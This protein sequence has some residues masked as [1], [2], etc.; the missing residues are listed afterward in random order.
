MEHSLEQELRDAGYTGDFALEPLIEACGGRFKSL[1][2][3]SNGRWTARYGTRR[4]APRKACDGAT[5]TEAVAMLYL[6]LYGKK[7]NNK[8][9]G[10]TSRMEGK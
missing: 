3:H 2:L 9:G 5:P 6:A 10:E 1:W 7:H 4:I 8:N